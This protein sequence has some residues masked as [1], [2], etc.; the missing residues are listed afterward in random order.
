MLL[1]LQCYDSYSTKLFYE[2]S[3]WQSSQKLFIGVRKSIFSKHH[4]S[5]SST[6]W[7]IGKI[8]MV[9]ILE[10]ANRRA[11]RSKTWASGWVGGWVALTY[12][13]GAFEIAVFKVILESFGAFVLKWP[14]L[15]K[16]YLQSET[17][18]NLGLGASCNMYIGYFDL[19]V[20]GHVGVI[21]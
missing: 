3:L 21:R 16:G 20:Q 15:E 18:R 6:L 11:K 5:F 13:W 19:S 7:P 10:M 1:L 17:E 14:G 8:R 12:I 9:N 4:F 2:G